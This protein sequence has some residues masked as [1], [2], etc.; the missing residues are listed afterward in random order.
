MDETSE[1][2]LRPMAALVSIRNQLHNLKETIVSLL[3]LHQSLPEGEI[4]DKYFDEISALDPIANAMLHRVIR[5]ELEKM[6]LQNVETV[7]WQKRN[8]N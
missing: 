6:D 3:E 7:C 1:S 8:W 2:A 4:R 5:G